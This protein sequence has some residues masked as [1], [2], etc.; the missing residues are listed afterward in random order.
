MASIQFVSIT[1]SGTTSFEIPIGSDGLAIQQQHY[2]TLELAIDRGLAKYPTVMDEYR[3]QGL[4]QT[5]VCQKLLYG[6][7]IEQFITE[8]L[9]Y[10]T[11]QDLMEAL[12]RICPRVEK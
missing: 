3:E 10:L 1:S 12:K 6:A 7:G 9:D 8:T 5:T 4:S 2:Q 11:A